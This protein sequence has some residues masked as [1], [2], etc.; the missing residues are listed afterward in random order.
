MEE[1][2]FISQ[3]G[4]ICFVLYFIILLEMNWGYDLC[5]GF[6]KRIKAVSTKE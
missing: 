6:V 3:L 5:E 2:V 4:F 1:C